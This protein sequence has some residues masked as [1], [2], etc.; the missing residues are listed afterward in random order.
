VFGLRTT[1]VSQAEIVPLG[2]PGRVMA[3]LWLPEQQR[4][5]DTE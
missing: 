2:T 4:V 5:L 3:F 1:A